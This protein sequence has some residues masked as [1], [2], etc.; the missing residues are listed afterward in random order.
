MGRL[1]AD[2]MKYQI[3]ILLM[4]SL[5]SMSAQ[6]DVN[7]NQ[8]TASVRKSPKIEFAEMSKSPTGALVRS[9][10]I[11]GWGQLYVEN[12]WKA[13]LM[14]GGFVG[15]GS[16]IYWNHDNYRSAIDEI[17]SYAGEPDDFEL[18]VLKN[19]RDFYRDQRDLGGLYMLGVYLISA[20]D[21]YVGAHLYDFNVDDDLSF[22]LRPNRM[23]M[24]EFQI[25]YRLK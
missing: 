1:S 13:P 7:D 17:E 4:F 6:D 14:F 9:L 5:Y 3:I 18:Q 8:D 21:A 10:L 16:I 23:G 15:V 24:I 2:V 19:K 25:K 11:P 12:Y 20:V 22:D